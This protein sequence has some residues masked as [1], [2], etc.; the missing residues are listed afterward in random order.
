MLLPTESNAAYVSLME[1]DA[2]QVVSSVSTEAA[3]FSH[4]FEQST[5]G[6]E[7]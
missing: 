3:M 2:T 7:C 6:V 1:V 5:S 4:Q